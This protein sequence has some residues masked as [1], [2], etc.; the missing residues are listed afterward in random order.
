MEFIT[1]P[2]RARKF[3]LKVLHSLE[4]SNLPMDR[5]SVMAYIESAY[6]LY[7]YETLQVK[8]QVIQLCNK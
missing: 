1:N 8:E 4:I 7:A 5:D 3:V 2:L 6:R